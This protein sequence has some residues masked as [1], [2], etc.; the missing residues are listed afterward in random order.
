MSWTG[1]TCGEPGRARAVHRGPMAVRT[2]GAG[3]RWRAHRSTA[4]GRSGALKLTSGGTIERGEH[5]ELDSGLTG[6]QAAVW[7]LGDA[8]AQRSHGNLGG[9]GFWC[10]RGEERGSVRCGVFRGSSGWLFLGWGRAPGGGGGR[11]NNSNE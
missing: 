4:S 6:A 10:G 9:E 5:G 7:R 2:E 3:A 8:V 1:S 11:N